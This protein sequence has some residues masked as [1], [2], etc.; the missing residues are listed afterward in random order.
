MGK[1]GKMTKNREFPCNAQWEVA[2]SGPEFWK[3]LPGICFFH[4]SVAL[5]KNFFLKS[6]K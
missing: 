5:S 2:N 4:N 3:I 6:K 1:S